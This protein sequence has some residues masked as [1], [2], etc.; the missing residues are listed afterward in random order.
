MS[1]ITSSARRRPLRALPLAAVV[2][3]ALAGCSV[4]SN[5]SS[6]SAASSAPAA[7]S[8]GSASTKITVAIVPKLLGLSVF[9]ANVKGAEQV[10]SMK[11]GSVIVD[12]AV[13][14]GGNVEGA[15]V[16][17]DVV[18]GGVKIVGIANLPGRIA[19][20]SSS[21][22]AR[23]LSAFVGLLVDKDGALL[24]GFD[25]EI[26]SAALITQGGAIVHSALKPA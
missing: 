1:G 22:Y 7:S 15:R 6:G 11:P 18:A 4:S 10:A 19:A 3:L 5:S 13:E 17:E 12:L 16:D 8:S 14:Q 25:D 23:N 2:A 21:L 26:L 24:P 9:E 20:D